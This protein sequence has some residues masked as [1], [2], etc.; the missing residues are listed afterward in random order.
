MH[1]RGPLADAVGCSLRLPGIFP[2]Y[3]YDGTLHVDGGVLDNLPVSALAGVEGPR[4]AVNIGFGSDAKPNSSTQSAG[5]PRLPGIA[6]TLIRT[7]TMGSGM[8][9]AATLAQAD[10]VIRPDTRGVGL[11][12]FHQ[13]DQARAAGRTATRE[14]LPQILA[15]LHR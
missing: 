2:P 3:A 4:V 14:A 12:E 13:I 1:R 9:A 8:A 15:L 5:P 10:I 11:L 6:D 7:M